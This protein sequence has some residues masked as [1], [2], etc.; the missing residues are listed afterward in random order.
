MNTFAL[1]TI[2]QRLANAQS[3]RRLAKLKFQQRLIVDNN[4]RY[5]KVLTVAKLLNSGNTFKQIG[6]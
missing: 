3:K 1:Q 2:D 6:V 4:T 5:E